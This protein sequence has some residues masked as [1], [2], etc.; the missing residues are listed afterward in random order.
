MLSK[1]NAR[2]LLKLND[3]L[4]TALVSTL[5]FP[6]V[7]LSEWL[8]GVNII[9][10]LLCILLSHN[11][12]IAKEERETGCKELDLCILWVSTTDHS[13]GHGWSNITWSE[14]STLTRLLS[15]RVLAVLTPSCKN[16]GVNSV[17][18]STAYKLYITKRSS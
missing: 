11:R 12:K 18:S 1:A 15:L 4:P 13:L 6:S 10:L 14:T 8:Q 17:Q 16:G 3:Y 2:R 5:Y 9:C 7:T